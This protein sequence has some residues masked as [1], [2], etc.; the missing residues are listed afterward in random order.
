MLLDNTPGDTSDL[1]TAQAEL[2]EG[3]T[4]PEA[5]YAEH[6]ITLYLGSQVLTEINNS[7]LK[8]LQTSICR[9]W[10]QVTAAAG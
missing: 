4:F 8:K 5:E 7:L 10:V 1:Y 3:Q 9:M 6:C 2:S